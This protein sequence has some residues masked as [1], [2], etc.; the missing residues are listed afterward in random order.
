MTD[1]RSSRDSCRM[2]TN[3][4]QQPVLLA[5]PRELDGSRGSALTVSE[6][7]QAHF[8]YVW[9]CLR[10][11]GVDPAT[12]DDAVQE[13]FLVVS[14][15]LDE[16][17]GDSKVST[18]LYSIVVYIAR[19]HRTSAA[20]QARRLISDSAG[21]FAEGSSHTLGDLRDEIEH[22]EQLALAQRALD[23]LDDAKREVFVLA[24]VEGMSAPEIAEVTDVPL[25]TVYSRLRVAKQQFDQAVENLTQS[26]PSAVRSK[27]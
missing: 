18:W 6:V 13:V 1:S 15:K 16:F 8:R 12:L 25:N 9:R 3:T 20:R 17:N 2:P 11:L 23:T 19:R 10:S 22:N 27:S 4:L 24:C 5:A 26:Q 7:Y 14:R 21:A